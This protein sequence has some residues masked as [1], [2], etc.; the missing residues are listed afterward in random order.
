[1]ATV[2]GLNISPSFQGNDLFYL[3]A[4]SVVFRVNSALQYANVLRVYTVLSRA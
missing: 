4:H 1:M 3:K 2:P